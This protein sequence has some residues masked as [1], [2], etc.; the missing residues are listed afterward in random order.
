MAKTIQLLTTEESVKMLAVLDDN[1]A[2]NYLRAAILEAQE[3]GLRDIIGGA[4]LDALKE[5]TATNTLTGA[6]LT[7]VEDYAQFYLA[8]K[9]R[10]ELL[11][12]VAYKVGN[13]GVVKTSDEHLTP[14]TAG[15]IE[16]VQAEA[17]A[18]ADYYAYRLQ[19]WVCDNAAALPELCE[20]DAA[21][22]RAN[23]RS[24]ATCNL[25]LGG[26]GGERL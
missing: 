15:E 26:P 12:K 1:I 8:Y 3:V 6:Y 20:S 22:I 17:Q 7:L 19:R 14:A 5:R 10:A 21:Q 24:A 2:A 25:W 18:K 23:L 9:C 13:A 4:L 11:G 16:A